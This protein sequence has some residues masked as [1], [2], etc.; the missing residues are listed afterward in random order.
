MH[1]D[2]QLKSNDTKR[3]SKIVILLEMLYGFLLDL[4]YI[5]WLNPHWGY[6]GFSYSFST[7]CVV[8][9]LFFNFLLSFFTYHLLKKRRM[10][11]NILI[12][13]INLYFFPQSTMFAL[14]HHNVSFFIFMSL[15]CILMVLIN[16]IMIFPNRSENNNL[17]MP[18]TYFEMIIIGLSLIMILISGLYSG[19][20]ISFDLSD[21]YEFRAD[22]RLYNIP[23]V[24]R[25]AFHWAQTFLPIGLLYS[26]TNKKHILAIFVALANI[27]CFSFNGKK[28]VL[29]TVLMAFIIFFFYNDK[30]HS[31]IP[32]ALN[33]LVVC[34]FGEMYLNNDASFIGTHFLRRLI[35][36]PS[37]L[38]KVYFDYFSN[39]EYD[40]LRSSILRRIGLES[41]YKNGIPNEIG[42][43]VYGR[44]ANANAG[45]CG[46]AFANFGW[47]SLLLYPLALIALFKVLEWCGA[48]IDIKMNLFVSFLVA[49][50]FISGSYFINLWTN[51]ILLLAVLLYYY[52]S[53]KKE[54]VQHEPNIKG[55]D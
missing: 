29:F 49:Y 37:Y 6:Y 28:S 36:I 8:A 2:E 44:S 26:L 15:F 11:D 51:G 3:I 41:P 22:Y 18:S 24:F 31:K 19:F 47:T 42:Y 52:P 43:V 13:I 53:S 20:R 17:T 48:R 55:E 54:K 30:N 35:F 21:Y 5:K 25:I 9:S 39:H 45:L 27:L 10:S 16:K 12:I 32:A 1:K 7:E 33:A 4:F 40:Y 38:G 46:D 34:S 23:H 50:A 14:S